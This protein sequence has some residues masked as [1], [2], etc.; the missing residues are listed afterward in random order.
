MALFVLI[1]DLTLANQA[2]FRI[3]SILTKTFFSTEQ[4]LN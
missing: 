4:K 2:E 1:I 3:F